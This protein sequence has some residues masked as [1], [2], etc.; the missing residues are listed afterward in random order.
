MVVFYRRRSSPFHVGL[1]NAFAD[2]SQGLF[3]GLRLSSCSEGRLALLRTCGRSE[4]SSGRSANAT[5]SQIESWRSSTSLRRLP[6]PSRISYIGAMTPIRR[7]GPPRWRLTTVCSLLP[8]REYSRFECQGDLGAFLALVSA[9]GAK[10]LS[11]L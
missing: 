5:R 1:A 2:V 3:S 11:A 7:L 9:T 10:L 6:K 8:D 4:P